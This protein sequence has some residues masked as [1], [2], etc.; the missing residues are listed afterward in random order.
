M[1]KAIKMLIACYIH[2]AWQFNCQGFL[3]FK[4]YTFWLFIQMQPG[5]SQ[6]F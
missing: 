6:S 1:K 4:I 3:V 5:N 2:V